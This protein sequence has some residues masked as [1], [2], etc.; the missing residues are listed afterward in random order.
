[1]PCVCWSVFFRVAC[2]SVLACTPP[3]FVCRA[4]QACIK[5]G[6]LDFLPLLHMCVLCLPTAVMVSNPHD[7]QGLI[8]NHNKLSHLQNLANTAQPRPQPASAAAWGAATVPQQALSLRSLPVPHSCGLRPVP[9]QSQDQPAN[10]AP[11]R[12]TDRQ[13][14]R[15]SAAHKQ[16]VKQVQCSHTCHTIHTL[17]GPWPKSPTPLTPPGS[18]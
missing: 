14:L 18:P 17:K 5:A 7:G 13:A 12:S 9:P 8:L 15:Q 3:R 16:S 6:W 2:S 4:S 1:M 10:K 11:G